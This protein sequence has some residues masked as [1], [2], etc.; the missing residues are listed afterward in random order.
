[1]KFAGEHADSFYNYQGFMEGALTSGIRA[2]GEL[3]DDIQ[4]GRL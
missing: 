2:A 1:M 4:A 3:L